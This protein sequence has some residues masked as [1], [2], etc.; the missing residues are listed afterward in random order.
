MILPSLVERPALQK[1]IDWR[2]NG[3]LQMYFSEQSLVV[4]MKIV[5]TNGVDGR[6]C[7]VETSGYNAPLPARAGGCL[8][9]L[10]T[11]GISFH[12]LDARVR[13]VMSPFEDATTERLSG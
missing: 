10:V 5:F 12:S 8:H 4:N 2:Q 13:Q 3:F 7:G 1:V 6:R 9:L 11:K